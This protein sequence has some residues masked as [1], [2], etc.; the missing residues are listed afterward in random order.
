[1][2]VNLPLFR[3]FRQVWATGGNCG[4]GG[5]WFWTLVFQHSVTF[6]RKLDS[7]HRD[8]F[9]PKLGAFREPWFSIYTTTPILILPYKRS[10]LRGV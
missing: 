8:N 6:Y 9:A 3:S 4:L 5:G 2:G 10:G 7:E 1:M